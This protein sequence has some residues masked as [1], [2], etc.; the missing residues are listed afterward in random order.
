MP[1]PERLSRH[2]AKRGILVGAKFRLHILARFDLTA[3][4]GF[5]F[6]ETRPGTS[7]LNNG[8]G[9][10]KLANNLTVIV[11]GF[12][13]LYTVIV[14]LVGALFSSNPIQMTRNSCQ[15]KVYW[16]DNVNALT[17]CLYIQARFRHSEMPT[18][19]FPSPGD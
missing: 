11:Y 7:G 9:V 16:A 18:T 8:F 2:I 12:N 10:V 15:D 5:R 19:D 1:K 4:R 17:F 6:A 14:Y 13:R 3:T